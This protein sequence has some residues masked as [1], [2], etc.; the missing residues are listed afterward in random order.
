MRFIS[1]QLTNAINSLRERENADMKRFL[2]C[3]EEHGTFNVEG[4]K[5]TSYVN[6]VCRNLYTTIQGAVD[7]SMMRQGRCG[8]TPDQ[9]KE[10]KY[11]PMPHSDGREIKHQRL[12][13][14]EVY[15]EPDDVNHTPCRICLLFLV[16]I[17]SFSF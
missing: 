3:V 1:K 2:L 14:F 4:N 11:Q 5:L 16:Y 6:A 10:F 9:I 15:L 13:N 7:L 12:T 8:S 17:V